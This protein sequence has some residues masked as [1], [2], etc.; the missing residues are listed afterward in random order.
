MSEVDRDIVKEAKVL[1]FL[2]KKVLP[3]LLKVINALTCQRA[4]MIYICIILY[5][6]DQTL[7]ERLYDIY[8]ATRYK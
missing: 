7:Y 8:W 4:L 3:F 1:P 6:I 2:R 5:N